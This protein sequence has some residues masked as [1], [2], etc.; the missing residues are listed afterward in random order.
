MDITGQILVSMPSLQDERFHRTVIYICA[1]SEEGS[2]GIIINKKIDH[3]FYPGLLKQ[4]G[5][6]NSVKDKKI[7]I[8]YGGPVES[9][10]G[11]ILHSDDFLHKES[12]FIDKGIALT[13][14]LEFFDNLS[15]GKGPKH[16]ILALG[17]AGWGEGQL[18]EE[19]KSN[20]WMITPIDSNF[21]FDEEV[22]SKWDKA[23]K[24]IGVDPFSVSHNSGRA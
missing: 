10:R 11:F 14:T 21:I 15:L 18:E 7:L 1:H 17:Y 13:S 23:Y 4:L 20:S 3:D 19:I 5:I 2:M 22:S 12:L 24:L 9:E 16:S 8:R 6:E